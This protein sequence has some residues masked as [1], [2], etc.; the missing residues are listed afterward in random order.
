M[1]GGLL[2]IIREW[3]KVFI[4]EKLKK[5]ICFVVLFKKSCKIILFFFFEIVF[6]ENFIMIYKD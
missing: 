4:I 5:V 1:V 2:I 3:M 6:V